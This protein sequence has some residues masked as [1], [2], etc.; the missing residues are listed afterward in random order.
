MNCA[1]SGG[2][3]GELYH[4]MDVIGRENLIECGSDQWTPGQV[5]KL[6]L[7]DTI[8]TDKVSFKYIKYVPCAKVLKLECT[9]L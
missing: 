5:V 9:P 7:H 1:E 3:S 2:Q 8:V 6:L 4:V